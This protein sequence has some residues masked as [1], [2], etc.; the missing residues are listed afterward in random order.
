MLAQFGTAYLPKVAIYKSG[1]PYEKSAVAGLGV[2]AL[3]AYVV[4]HGIDIAVVQISSVVQVGESSKPAQPSISLSEHTA[5]TGYIKHLPW[6]PGR[7]SPHWLSQHSP[8]DV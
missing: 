7:T 6:I 2:P 4:E 5:K 8:T 3:Q 1:N